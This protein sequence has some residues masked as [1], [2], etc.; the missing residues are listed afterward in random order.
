MFKKKQQNRR[1]ASEFQ[2]VSK[3]FA[4]QIES[5]SLYVESRG[6]QNEYRE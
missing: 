1:I 5:N 6:E 3:A 4:H 2:Y